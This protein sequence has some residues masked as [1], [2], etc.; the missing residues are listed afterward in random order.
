M[1]VVCQEMGWDYNQYR[2]QPRW[3]IDLILDKM[4]IDSDEMKKAQRRIKR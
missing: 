2:N 3:F 1:I 4:E